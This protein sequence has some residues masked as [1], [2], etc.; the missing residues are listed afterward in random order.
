M[1]PNHSLPEM[2]L[3]LFSVFLL[4]SAVIALIHTDGINKG[5]IYFYDWANTRY[6]QSKNRSVSRFVFGF[7][8]FPLIITRAIPHQGWKAGL[9]LGIG[10]TIIALLV[11]LSY[12]VPWGV[13]VL[14]VLVA[15]IFFFS[16]L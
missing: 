3:L 9:T 5:I 8:R 7:L 13:I 14:F 15:A 10:L 4:L 12:T 1:L 2:V 11:L 16:R 6:G